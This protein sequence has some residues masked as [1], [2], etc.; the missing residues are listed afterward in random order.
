[1]IFYS[2]SGNVSQDVSV[3]NRQSGFTLIE[4]MVVVVIL[5][6][7]AAMM[8]MSVGSTESRKNRAFY[9][10]LIDSLQYVRLLSA[11]Q[12][13]PMG[14]AMQ[15]KVDGQASPVILSLSDPYVF[16]TTTAVSSGDQPKNAMELS[17]MSSDEKNSQKPT[18]QPEPSIT[19]PELPPDVVL[20]ISSLS[21]QNKS[22]QDL[23]PWFQGNDVP[24]VLWYGTGEASPVTIEVRYHD[25]L[26]GEVITVMPNGQIKVGQS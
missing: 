8:T 17:A 14:L 13:Q 11:E 6:V 23:Q 12:M 18:W 10:H 25:R 19:L 16:L 7:F 5:S 9:E 1:M 24:K 4:M 2:N 20:T 22:T 21:T 3:D 26:V 15:S